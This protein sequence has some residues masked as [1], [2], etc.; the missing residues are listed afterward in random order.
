MRNKEKLVIHFSQLL[1]TKA[2]PSEDKHG[3]SE[4]KHGQCYGYGANHC[5]Y[6]WRF[7]KNY[8]K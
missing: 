2:F 6:E 8:L 4:R 1:K 7:F 5:V 3:D